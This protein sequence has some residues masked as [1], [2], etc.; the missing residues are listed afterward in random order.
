MTTLHVNSVILIKAILKI[1]IKCFIIKKKRMHSICVFWKEWFQ[2][3]YDKGN[4]NKRRNKLLNTKTE[5]CKPPKHN[6]LKN[7]VKKNKSIC[8]N[9]T[10]IKKDY[11]KYIIYFIKL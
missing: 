3:V 6:S 1:H 2:D 11:G 4:I 10:V 5:N 8:T 7:Q 9:N